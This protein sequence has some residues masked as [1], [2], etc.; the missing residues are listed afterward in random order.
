MVAP[1]VLPSELLQ[2]LWEPVELI[3]DRVSRSDCFVSSPR[4]LL[5][6]KMAR[7][8]VAGCVVASGSP[9]GD[10]SVVSLFD[11]DVRGVS[12]SVGCEHSG[13]VVS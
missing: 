11:D 12:F 8:R 5:I 10:A 4:M 13:D 6:E 2:D 3:G 9:A 7:L 1:I